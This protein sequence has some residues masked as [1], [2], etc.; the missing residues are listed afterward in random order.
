[1]K[2]ILLLIFSLLI[3]IGLYAQDITGV[4]NGAL[5]IQG[6]QLRLVFHIEQ[7]EEGYTATMDSPDQG[8]TGIPVNKIEFNDSNLRI[9]ITAIGMHYDAVWSEGIFTGTFHQSG[10]EFPLDLKR[11]LIE[12]QE[13]KRPQNPIKPYPY[14]EREVSI[15]N[16]ADGVT[17]SGT[18]TIP[19]NLSKVPVAILISGSG[20]QDRNEELLGHKPFL[21]ISDFLTR[22]GIAVLRYDDRGVGK[23]TGD[24][25]S[26]TSF[27]FARDA[28]SAL[29]YLKSVE[30]IDTKRI[31]Y[32]GHSEG[33]LIAPMIAARNKNVNF[34]VMLAGPGIRGA[35]LL[36]KQIELIQ[37]VGGSS[38]Q[39]IEEV[40]KSNKKVF[41]IVVNNIEENEL[42]A[43]LRD[44]LAESYQNSSENQDKTEEEFID[45]RMKTVVSPWF[46]TFLRYDPAESL[47]KVKC[48]VF[49]VNGEKDLQVPAAENIKAIEKH[50]SQ[51]KNKHFETK[52][53]AGLNHLFQHTKTGS[54]E[55]YATIEETF[56]TEVLQDIVD[57]LKQK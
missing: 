12:K 17:L 37:R 6:M 11:D 48:R 46:K 28:E 40:I 20:P 34:I 49:A 53:Y 24:F 47:T 4:W 14:E 27:D 26:A 33:G 29:E 54:P 38:E 55:E 21:V 25:K 8:A 57:W 16:D 22:N 45:E 3:V 41:D 5:Q 35:E 52:I 36:L 19:E 9:E 42:E 32:I 2:K 43:K 31:G 23:S 1:M 30:E 39:E 18:L 15:V 10:Y 50:L 56:S 7:S 51:A 44:Y 13:F